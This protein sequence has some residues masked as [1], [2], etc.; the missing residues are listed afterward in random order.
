MHWRVDASLCS[1][2]TAFAKMLSWDADGKRNEKPQGIL[3]GPVLTRKPKGA[4][5]H[6]GF[7]PCS[8]T[9]SSCIASQA[10]PLI[11]TM[12]VLMAPAIQGLL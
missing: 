4:G 11:H 5:K 7:R 3:V 9:L 1:E 12:G 8:G 2:I 6:M 10:G